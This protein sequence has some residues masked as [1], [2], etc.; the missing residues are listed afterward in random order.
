MPVVEDQSR[1]RTTT[2]GCGALEPRPH[3]QRGLAAVMDI[4]GLFANHFWV[5]AGLIGLAVALTFAVF[6][7]SKFEAGYEKGEAADPDRVARDN[8]PDEW[9]KSHWVAK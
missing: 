7:W 6:H 8:P 1:I 5:L 4:S 9:C 2:A 3:D